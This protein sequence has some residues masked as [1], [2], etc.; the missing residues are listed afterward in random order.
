MADSFWLSNQEDLMGVNTDDSMNQLDNSNVWIW[1]HF[2]ICLGILAQAWY[3]G[4]TVILL[5]LIVTLWEY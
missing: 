5:R 3:D 1:W 2:C 4:V